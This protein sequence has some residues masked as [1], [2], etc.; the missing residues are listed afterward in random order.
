MTT[1]NQYEHLKID[2][3]TEVLSVTI[4][5]TLTVTNSRDETIKIYTSKLDSGNWVYGYSV[6]W[7]NGRTSYKVPA[8][9]NGLFRTQRE[10]CL[11]AIGFMLIY[12]DYFLPETKQSLFQIEAELLQAGLF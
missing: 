7:A 2:C 10:A 6:Y 3:L 4:Q 8:T 11:Y 9:E 1:P 12:K 5:D